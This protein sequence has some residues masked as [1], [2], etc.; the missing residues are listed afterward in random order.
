M[1]QRDIVLG[2]QFGGHDTAAGLMIDG[3]LLAACEQERYC[4]EKHTRDFPV[5]AI[6]DCL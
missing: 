2:I 1:S 6:A 5:D 3:R 4:G